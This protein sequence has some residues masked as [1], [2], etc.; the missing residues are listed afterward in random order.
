MSSSGEDQEG[1]SLC[2]IQVYVPWFRTVHR[3]LD[4]WGGGGGVALGGSVPCLHACKLVQVGHTCM[5]V[6]SHLFCACTCEGQ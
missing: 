6:C 2:H 4:R 5:H 1:E 3:T